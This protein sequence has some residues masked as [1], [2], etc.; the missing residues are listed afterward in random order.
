MLISFATLVLLAIWVALGVW[1]VTLLLSRPR[2]RWLGAALVVEAALAVV[3]Q[4]ALSTIPF[5]IGEPLIRVK[6]LQV[7]L[8]ATLAFVAVLGVGGLVYVAGRTWST[9]LEHGRRLFKFAALLVAVPLVASGSLYGLAQASLPPRERERDPSKRSIKLPQG[10]S[11]SIYAEGTM[12][13]PTTMT[14]GPD[15]KLYIGDIS[16]TLWVATDSKGTCKVDSIKRFADGFTLLLGLA[17]HGNELYVASAGKIEALRD[18]KG[19]GVA[20]Q[21][22]VVVQGLPSMVLM[23]HS[24]NGIAFGPDG[25]LYFGVGSTSEGQVEQNDHAAAVLSVKPDGSDLRVFAR[26]FGNPFDIAF[27]REGQLFGGDN[28]PQGEGEDPPDEYNHIVEGGHYGFPY[29]YGDP[30]DNGG[31]IGAMVTFPPHATPTGTTFY[32]GNT[33]PPEYRDSAFVA[34]WNRGEIARVEVARAPSGNYLGHAT[35]FGSGFLYPIAVTNGPDGNL[36]VADFG[37]SAIYR[38]TYDPNKA[39]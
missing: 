36:Y 25:R 19:T 3:A 27:N 4:V 34:L 17:W 32:V 12:D 14:F 37:T 26:G 10:F 33:Y 30:P 9:R 18:T 23:P 21:R 16:G 6:L 13:N 5:G 20:D 2:A 1:G 11:W 29:F 38:I 15:K 7:V 24:N 35:T 8:Q 28:S 31:T 39:Y 22:R